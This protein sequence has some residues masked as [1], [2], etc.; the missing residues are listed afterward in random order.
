VSFTAPSGGSGYT[1]ALNGDGVYGDNGE[2]QAATTWA[3]DLPGVVNVGVRYTD[4]MSTAQKIVQPL[5]V[6]GPP[7]NFVVFPPRP[8]P[9]EPVTFAFSPGPALP[10][11]PEWDL[12][13]DG[14]FPDATGQQA[15]RTFPSPGLYFVGLRVTDVDD[16]VSTAY[17]A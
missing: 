11:P 12:N 16:A 17:Q 4:A 7:A 13:G 15:T 14:F 3:Y 10:T 8:V 2:G 5:Q 1:W 6:N 9:G